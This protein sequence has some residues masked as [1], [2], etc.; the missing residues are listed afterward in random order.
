MAGRESARRTIVSCTDVRVVRCEACG[1]E[2][3]HFTKAYGCGRCG[4]NYGARAPST[5]ANA[6]SAKAPA[7]P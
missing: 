6:A 7:A 2:G 1:G 5:T 3:R 4:H